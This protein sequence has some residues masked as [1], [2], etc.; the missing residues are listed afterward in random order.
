MIMLPGTYVNPTRCID[1]LPRLAMPDLDHGL[2]DRPHEWFPEYKPT[3]IT[4]GY[5]PG[6]MIRYLRKASPWGDVAFYGGATAVM[7]CVLPPLGKLIGVV[8]AASLARSHIKACEREKSLDFKLE[9]INEATKT[10]IR[11][12]NAILRSITDKAD[13][14][15][16]MKAKNNEKYKEAWMGW[17]DAQS[18]TIK[19]SQ[20][21]PVELLP[22]ALMFMLSAAYQRE[23][24]L[25]LHAK[26]HD[27]DDEDAAED[28]KAVKKYL[29]GQIRDMAEAL[30]EA[31][32]KTF[33][34][35]G[36]ASVITQP[37]YD[38]LFTF[39]I[40]CGKQRLFK[41]KTTLRTVPLNE[42]ID[43]V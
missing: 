37:D 9:L 23:R 22:D 39:G 33:G 34:Y 42:Y 15:I 12:V 19:L 11:A 5:Q 18:H 31:H 24:F 16:N 32:Y 4:R 3:S 6:M 7:L 28:V 20:E 25:C 27:A 2:A 1:W 8:A 13:I 36:Y 35:N 29:K 10:N 40:K 17:Y 14:H 30:E 41:I 26:S 43:W 21:I 38:K